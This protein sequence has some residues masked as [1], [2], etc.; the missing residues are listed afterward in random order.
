MYLQSAADGLSAGVVSG[1]AR[2]QLEWL[3]SVSYGLI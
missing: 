3:I 1:L 2:P